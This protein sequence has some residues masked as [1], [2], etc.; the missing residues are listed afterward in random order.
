L[1]RHEGRFSD[2][3]EAVGQSLL[4]RAGAWP[5]PP[6]ETGI[7]YR[8]ALSYL[9]GKDPPQI[10]EAFWD[11][12]RQGVV[13]LGRNANEPGWPAYRLTRFGRDVAA[14]PRPYF[15][16]IS[17][18][19]QMIKGYAPD[20]SVEAITYLEEA[21]ATFYADCLLSS[22]IM[23]GVAAEAEFLR[24][25]DTAISSATYGNQFNSLKRKDTIAEKIRRFGNQ[26]GPLKPSLPTT[27]VEDLDVNFSMI[28]S[29]LRVSRNSAGHPSAFSAKREQVYVNLQLFGPFARQLM[30]LREALK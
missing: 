10:L 28:Q 11:L 22:T 1:V 26:L 9:N 21:V 14:Q 23:L 20:L 25:V 16:S 13:T 7:A 24:L 12:F 15:H 18:Y 5:L 19:I 30:Y 4:K 2:L 6:G 17:S 3:S 8:G 29:V 27:A